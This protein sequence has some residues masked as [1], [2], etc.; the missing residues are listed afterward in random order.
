MSSD[1]KIAIAEALSTYFFALDALDDSAALLACYTEDAV[2]ECY[3]HGKSEPM[4]RIDSHDQIER[5]IALESAASQQVLLRHHLTGLVF[6]NL[7]AET[8]TTRAKVLVTAQRLD[9]PAPQ[10]RNT[11]TCEG[12]WRR[13]PG[14][15]K[16]ARWTIRRDPAA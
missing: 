16:L 12:Q 4:M 2:W 6:R 10:V 14:G 8:A 15:W 1:D 5:L 13:T 11:A 3:D 7:T 9:D